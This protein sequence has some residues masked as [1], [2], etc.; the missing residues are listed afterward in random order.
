MSTKTATASLIP[1]E[2]PAG[3]VAGPL[4]FRVLQAG[5]EIAVQD[6]PAPGN[7]ASFSLSAGTYQMEV[8]RLDGAGGTL[9]MPQTINFTVDPPPP[10]VTVM[11]PVAVSV[12]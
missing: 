3:T 4:R 10:P 11:V 7:A 2:F 12:G 6:V 9:G 1:G 8:K 5:T